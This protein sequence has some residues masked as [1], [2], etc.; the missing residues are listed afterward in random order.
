MG[1]TYVIVWETSGRSPF[2]RAPSTGL[3]A[4]DHDFDTKYDT[5]RAWHH[6]LRRSPHPE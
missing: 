1:I 5:I 3:L 6:A 4:W 2:L